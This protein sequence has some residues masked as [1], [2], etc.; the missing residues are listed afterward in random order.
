[1]AIPFLSPIGNINISDGT[2]QLKLTDTSSSATTTLTLDGVNFT[3]QNNGTNGEFYMKSAATDNFILKLNTNNNAVGDSAKVIFND[4]GYVGWDGYVTLGDNGQNKDIRLRAGVGNIYFQTNNNNRMTIKESTGYVGIGTITP[5]KKLHILTADSD[6]TPQLLIQNSSTGDANILFNISGDSYSVGIDNSDSDKFKISAG[7]LGSS[8]RFTIDSSGNIKVTKTLNVGTDSPSSNSNYGSGDLNVENDTYASAQIMSHNSTAGNFSFLGIGKSSGTGAS[9]TIVQADE[10]VGLIGFYG[11]DGAAYKRIADIRSKID[12][13]PGAGDMPGNLEFWT[14][15]DGASAPTKR[16]T[17]GQ[18][19]AATFGAG[20]T[21]GATSGGNSGPVTIAGGITQTFQGSGGQ[22]TFNSHTNSTTAS[23]ATD[24]SSF[25]ISQKNTSGSAIEY[26]QGVIADG[27][28]FFGKWHAGSITGMGLNVATGNATFSGKMVVGDATDQHQWIVNKAVA[29]YYSGIKLTRGA[30]NNSSTSANNHAI[31]V[32]DTG[33]N[34]GKTNDATVD[35]FSNVSTHLTLNASGNATFAG[36]VTVG[37][38]ITAT[39]ADMSIA[40]AGGPEVS[41]RR[42]DTSISDGDRLG[43]IQFGGDDPTDGTFNYGVAIKAMADGTWQGSQYPGELLFQTRNQ[44]G[45]LATS[46][47]LNK[48]QSATFAGNVEVQN[49][50]LKVRDTSSNLQLTM[51]ASVG[52]TSRIMAHNN[53]L[54]SNHD[55][56]IV[57][58][59]IDFLTGSISGS[60]NSRALFLDSSRNATFTGT[61]AASGFTGNVTGTATGLAGTPAISVGNITTSGYLR[62]PSSFTIDPATHGNNTG[63]VVIAGNLQVDGTHTTINSTTVTIDDLVFNIASDA[64]DSAACNGAGITIGDGTTGADANLLYTHATASWDVNKHF[65]V[66]GGKITAIPGSGAYDQLKIVNVSTDNTNKLAGIYTL[67]YQNNNTSIMQFSGN[68]GGNTVYYGSADGNYRGITGHRFYVNASSTATSG[69]TEALYIAGNTN[70]TFA[71]TVK[72][73]TLIIDDYGNSTASD[74]DGWRLNSTSLYGQ[75]DGVDKVSISSVTGNASF[76]GTLN[77]TGTTTLAGLSA[78][79]LTTPIIQLQ[80]DLNVLNKAQTAYITLADR[81]TSGSEVVYNLSNL[82]TATFGGNVG[83]GTISP[84]APL[85]ILKAAGGANIVTALKL[86]PDDATVG[87]GTSIDFNASSTNTGASLVGSRI[88]GVREAANASGYLSFYTSPDASGSVP[89]ER[90]RIT[91]SGK[92][93][94]GGSHTPTSQVHIKNTSGDNRGLIIENTVTTSYSELSLKAAREFRIGTGGSGTSANAASAFYVYDAT[95]GGTAG[96]RFEISSAGDVQA[97]RVRSNT[98]GEVALSIQ[99]SDSTIHYGFRI[100]QANNYLNIDRVDSAG[101]LMILDYNGNATFTGDVYVNGG[102]VRNASSS[103]TKIYTTY[104]STEY[105]GGQASVDYWIGN[106]SVRAPKFID[107]NDTSYYLDPAN[108][109]TS[110]NVAGN[111]IGV[112]ATFAGDVTVESDGGEIFLKSADYTISRIIPRGTGADLDK[113]L[114]SLMDT[115]TEDV[116]IDTGGN[117]WINS[118]YNLGIGTTSPSSL[119]HIKG[120]GDAIRVESTNTGSGGAQI[121]LLHFTTSPADEDINSLINFGGY[122][123]GTT[124]VY[125]ASIRSYW[126]D[127]SERHGRLEFWT[128]DETISKALTLAHDNSATFAGKVAIGGASQVTNSGVLDVQLDQTNGTLGAANTAHFG[129]HGANT[130]GEISGITFGYKENGNASYRKLAIVSE[131]RGD[132]AARQNLHLLVNTQNGSNSASLADS[133]LKLDGLTRDATF[134]ESVNIGASKKI[135]LGGSTARMHIYHTGSSGEAT[136]LTKEGNLNLVNQSHGDDIVFK[137]ENSSGTVVTPLTLDSAGAATFAGSVNATNYKINGAQGSDGQVLTST[138]SGVAWETPSTG[139]S[140]FTG[141]TLT[142]SILIDYTGNDGNNNDA[143]LKVMNDASDWGIYVRKDSNAN[144]GIRIDSGGGDAFNI[145]STTGGSTKVFGV[146]GS[147]GNTTIAG[148]IQQTQNVNAIGLYKQ[149]NSN[150]GS[151][152]YTSRKWYND[153][154]GF[155]E[156][157]R[158]SSTRTSAGQGVKSFNM[159]NSHDINFWSGGTHTLSLIG[160]NATF[161]GTITN[162]GSITTKASGASNSIVAQWQATDANNCATFRTTDSGK[163]FRVHAQNSGT[164]YVQNDDGSNYLKIPDSGSNEVAGNTTFTGDITLGT[165]STNSTTTIYG[166]SNNLVLRSQ[167]SGTRAPELKF[168]IDGTDVAALTLHNNTSGIATNTLAYSISGT[169]KHYFYSDGN[170]QTVGYSTCTMFRDSNDTSYY[171]DPN[172]TGTSLNVAG[173]IS[174]TG[175]TPTAGTDI[176]QIYTAT[177]SLTVTTA[178]QDTGIDAT[179]L[180]TGTYIIQM[181]TDDHGTNSIGHYSEYYSGIMSWYS[182]NT[183]A[184]GTDEIIL[185]RA[186]HAANHGD[187]FLRIERTLSADA[188]DMHLQIKTSNNASGAANYVFKFRRMI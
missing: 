15:A 123:T 44:T 151:S 93:A 163:I 60:D 188:N 21:T 96:H 31:W 76:S 46:L 103:S 143:A 171:L 79:S 184:T 113:G 157:W 16:L 158:N 150:G 64:G 29:G 2:P 92:I 129:K 95:A 40:H 62:G 82:G 88:I 138:G 58:T 97:R 65:N 11:Y 56:D 162:V 38:D 137:T 3:L 101:N 132:G 57:S 70:A 105:W 81:D 61:V 169:P 156:L 63:T 42:D 13:T 170:F 135:Y 185:H 74:A 50:Q 17:I 77:V 131:G 27:N 54:G 9:P 19:G 120:T 23:G 145:Y 116:R 72:T 159:Y 32:S 108:T 126:T 90:M 125:G 94:V 5:E 4:R 187:V 122:Y 154:A 102:D 140:T 141:G 73:P 112:G 114:F 53:N 136:V 176:D 68:N 51:Q 66:L 28:A 109:G 14:T 12:G 10:T 106:T 164:I 155:G 43:Q 142:N 149:T 87:S 104:N 110:L 167:A 24:A 78:T 20:I 153:D 25:L 7:N 118:G 59:Q 173:N 48:D 124:S 37:G 84:D 47:T 186:G 67:N 177:K 26:R 161:A 111:I 181:Y 39:G 107:Q 134:A 115:G 146:N 128:T 139:G 179:D 172:S 69:H 178:W 98:A 89:L 36:T 130:S 174:H 86:D 75:T 33:L 22:T 152:A 35:A 85:H 71:G 52:G 127:V 55:L 45:S 119:L 91:S 34:F 166:N 160:N 117:S 168:N 180:A 165:S 182:S 144:Y 133:A 6:H 30:G 49:S 183:N 121:D 80:G 99:P 41:L 147:N 148:E 1:M 18:A 175:L 100:D 83:M 8:D